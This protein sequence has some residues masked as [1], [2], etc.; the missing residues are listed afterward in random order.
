[1]LIPGA[2]LGRLPYEVAT[3]GY[4]AEGNEWSYFMLLGS[5]FILNRPRTAPGHSIHPWIHQQSNVQ[6]RADQF[7]TVCV[8]DGEWAPAKLCVC[9]CSFHI[10]IQRRHVHEPTL[11]C[12]GAV[13]VI[14]AKNPPPPGFLSM[15]AGD[16]VEVY[17]KQPGEHDVRALVCVDLSKQ[18]H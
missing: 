6:A 4:I 5:D 3:R 15:C 11:G 18:V 9:V 14:P 13:A 12:A 16:F 2:G 10:N 7:R 8:P 1:V 17:S